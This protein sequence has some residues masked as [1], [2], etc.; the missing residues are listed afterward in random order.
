MFMLLGIQ[1]DAMHL[2]DQNTN[3]IFNLS[4][5]GSNKITL[6]HSLFRSSPIQW[7]YNIVDPLLSFVVLTWEETKVL[8]LYID[9]I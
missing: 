4:L 5:M 7:K 1:I 6:N 3:M 9:H 8:F 2:T